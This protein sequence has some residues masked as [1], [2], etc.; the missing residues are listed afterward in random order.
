MADISAIKLPDGVT[1]N[2]KDKS[3]T[4]L[5]DGSATGS[6]RGIGNGIVDPDSYEIGEYSFVE[7]Y[8]NICSGN[9]AHAEGH[10]THA[11]GI[12]SHS[13]GISTIAS[14]EAFHA[15]G[16]GTQAIPI[17]DNIYGAHAEGN[18]TYSKGNGS[19]SEGV[20]S[21]AEGDASHAEGNYTVATG[22]ASHAD[23]KS[24][25]A[26]H[27]SQHTFG[28]YNIEDASTA[29]ATNRGNYVEIVGNGTAYNKRSNARTLDWSGNEVLAGK[30]TVGA[31]GTNSMDVAT[32]GQLP[33]V[34]ANIVNT[35]TTTAGAHTA[36]S[37]QK[38]N[39]SFNVP[40]KTSHLTNDSGFITNH[41][42]ISGK[43]DK[44][45]T[46]SG[47]G[48]TDAK[49]SNGTITL[50]SNTI[51]PLTSYTETDPVF[52]ASAAH[53][54]TS[55]DIINWNSKQAALVSGTNIKTINNQSILGSGNISIGD[56]G[57]VL[58]L[59]LEGQDPHTGINY[60]DLTNL[61][62][63]E[64]LMLYDSNHWETLI[65]ELQ[66]DFSS[67]SSVA[68]SGSYNDLTNKPTIPD[69]LADLTSDS[70]HRTVTDTEKTTWNGKSDFSGDYNDL[71][72]KPTIPQDKVFIAE[73]DVTT[74][75]EIAQA[76]V[77]GKSVFMFDGEY[78]YAYSSHDTT[79]DY[80][81]FSRF[82][83]NSGV[84]RWRIDS[85]D[86]WTDEGIKQFTDSSNQTSGTL[87][88]ARL[89]VLF[90]TTETKSS[91]TSLNYNT[92]KTITVTIPAQS[93]YELV[94]VVGVTTNHGYASSIG[95]FKVL[96]SANRTVAV[97][98]TNRNTTAQGNFTDLTVTVHCL[99][100]RSN[101]Y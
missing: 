44:A 23:G 101:I 68:T 8:D 14:G 81:W 26:N 78:M 12:S 1:Y 80:Y 47:Y 98:V 4:N 60:F 83:G 99:W 46:L 10:T 82:Y 49:I 39:V 56:A 31:I 77:D 22:F 53:G 30:L 58:T 33:T 25:I 67:L 95:G 85:T 91:V 42:D 88:V 45:T 54:I 87:P 74:H 57:D 37:S 97:D 24:T 52:T 71:S 84:Q 73:K 51:T 50:G 100:A 29:A 79:N 64:G 34:P 65:S 70:T 2:I 18:T 32:V 55:S 93:G 41:Q 21:R 69:E 38:G 6:I 28:E 59:S 92:G 5:V 66:G 15:E 62:T 43:A 16:C 86:T 76:L 48:I 75:A 89:P 35:I 90:K 9:Y 19:H 61:K 3:L 63:G 17:K 13:E 72:N 36:I 94:G 27:S 7:G 11:T 20:G 40:T 96:S